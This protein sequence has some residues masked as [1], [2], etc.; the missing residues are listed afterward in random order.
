MTWVWDNYSLP[1]AVLVL[2]HAERRAH[3]QLA[4]ALQGQQLGSA[5]AWSKKAGEAFDSFCALIRDRAVG[6]LPPPPAAAAQPSIGSAL[7][8]LGI[9]QDP[10]PA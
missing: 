1:E 6:K 3:A 5:S 8:M 9:P 4:L 10:N 7:A 2:E